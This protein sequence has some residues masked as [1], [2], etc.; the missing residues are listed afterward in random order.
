MK[1]IL[2]VGTGPVGSAVIDHLKEC[3][4]ASIHVS[5]FTSK[6]WVHQNAFGNDIPFYR[7]GEGG[8]RG[9][10]HRVS[11]LSKATREEFFCELRSIVVKKFGVTK[12][13]LNA[14]NA[15]DEVEFVPYFP[16]AFQNFGTR[17]RGSIVRKPIVRRIEL[18]SDISEVIF[19]GGEKANYDAIF[20]CAGIFGNTKILDT[21]GLAEKTGFLG[22]H[23]VVSIDEKLSPPKY[24]PVFQR[25]NTGFLRRYETRGGF[26][27]S[28]RPRGKGEKNSFIY[29]VN[30][31]ELIAKLARQF[32]TSSFK[33]AFH[34]RYGFRT[35][36]RS[37]Q[38][39]IQ[40]PQ[41]NIYVWNGEKIVLNSDAVADLIARLERE[42]GKQKFSIKSGIH[43][44]GSVTP[45]ADQEQLAR[46]NIFIL[47][48]ADW[49]SAPAHHFTFLNVL[50]ALRCANQVMQS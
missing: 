16:R 31:L 46:R 9:A 7:L 35:N 42:F 1:K 12:A 26:K 22:D 32:D 2:V 50:R 15:C 3:K 5:E 8:M 14:A 47:G 23:L 20:V 48:G 44:W 49:Q 19:D 6:N 27:V 43:Y 28:L 11:D 40:V 4:Q 10:W 24:H 37:W 38:R 36:V 45:L 33:Q 21:S 29:S 18:R 13:V 34:L 25:L 39:F 17:L 30:S 41:K